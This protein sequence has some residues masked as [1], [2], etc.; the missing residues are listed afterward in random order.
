MRHLAL[1]LALLCY[2]TAIE[3][4]E[5]EQMDRCALNLGSGVF[6]VLVSISLRPTK[7]QTP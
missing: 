1:L 6:W 4:Y 2:W 5:K 7:P 3:R